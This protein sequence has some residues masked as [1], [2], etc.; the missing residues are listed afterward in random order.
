MAV[1]GTK[2]LA[3]R[4]KPHCEHTIL[5]NVPFRKAWHSTTA[6]ERRG[7]FVYAGKPPTGYD[8]SAVVYCNVISPEEQEHILGDLKHIF[9]HRRYER[10]HWDAVIVK[11]KETELFNEP[12][13]LSE[14]SR[15]V[16]QR[17]RKHLVDHRHIKPDITWLPSHAIELHPDG[18][19]RAHI[20]SVRFSGHL[21]AGLSLGTS[22]IMRLQPPKDGQQEDSDHGQS[23]GDSD[24][25][26]DENAGYVDLLL[27]P[28]SLY[29]LTGRSR[30]DYTHELLP[31]EAI[32]V[33][34]G[35]VVRRNAHRWSIIF[36][37]SKQHD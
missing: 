30:Y 18:E 31:N 17:I 15:A 21:V 33:G 23:G 14:T 28:R 16:L 36:R 24:K 2:R 34:T 35:Q 37:D 11:Y 19:L 26:D 13:Q 32:F 5:P 9:R 25:Y 8:N 10:G 22:A 20:D 7:D 3:L 4:I 27:Q 29:V 6:G 1:V 12:D